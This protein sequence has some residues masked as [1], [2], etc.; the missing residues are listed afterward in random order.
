MG[1][2]GI[3]IV[4]STGTEEKMVMLG[5]LSQTAV[6]LGMPL[7]VFITGTAIP[8]F[9]K[10]GYTKQ[11]VVPAGFEGFMKELREGLIKVKF[12]GWHELL[13]NSVKDGDAKVYACSLMSSALNLQKKDFDPIVEDIVG[14]TN[15]MIQSAENQIIM[16]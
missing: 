14:A 10:D 11:P 4:I 16:L 3:S 15:F 5:V 7:R 6:N 13:Q 12:Q 2:K 9:L 1:E 8:L